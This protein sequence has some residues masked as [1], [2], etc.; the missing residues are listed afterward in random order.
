MRRIAIALTLF[1]LLAGVYACSSDAPSPTTPKG[2]GGQPPSGSNGLVV[3]LFTSNPNPPEESCTIIQAIVTRNGQSVADGTGVSFSS[4]FGVFEQNLLNVVSII[5]QNGAATTALCS[6]DPGSAVVTARVRD[7]ND[8]ASAT[9][10]IAFQPVAQ[11]GP[12]VTFCDPSFGPPGGG[13]TLNINGGRFFGSAGSTRV[14]FS[15]GGATREALVTNLT[16]DTITL[17]T[18]SFPEAQSP[19][20]PVEIR[21]TLGTNTS[22]PVT[23]SLPN[24]FAFGTGPSTQASITAVLPSSGPNEGNTRVTIIGSGFRAPLQVFFGDT[25]AT[26]ISILFNQIIALTPAAFGAGANN[27]NSSVD[28]RVRLVDSGQEA[29]LG[30]GFRY[31]VDNVITSISPPSLNITEVGRVPVTLFGQGFQAPVAVSL[32]GITATVV[33]VSATEVVVMPGRPFVNNCQDLGGPSR[34]VNV[35]TGDVAVGPEFIYFVEPTRPVVVSMTPDRGRNTVGDGIA[36][37]VI[38]FRG[39]TVENADQARFGTRTAAI[40]DSGVANEVTAVLPPS[41]IL[42]R[43]ACPPGIPVDTLLPVETVGVTLVDLD[44]NCGSTPP[45]TFTYVLPCTVPTPTP[46]PSPTVTP[47]P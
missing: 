3:R 13:T 47:T 46:V 41:E 21:V 17:V 7:G 33:S 44:T 8:E 2:P 1:A 31:V 9:I 23:L 20:V 12:F 18:P 32:A 4:N 10:T 26:V 36:D 37:P 38:T 5:T 11:L 43:P 28:V 25:E 27:L 14:V 22:N 39:P 6:N 24:C 45:I 40:I 29:V 15:A 30:S 16:G 42:T 19:S 35:T 34:I